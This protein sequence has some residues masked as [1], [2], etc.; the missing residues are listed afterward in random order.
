MIRKESASGKMGWFQPREQADYISK[1][2]NPREIRENQ[3]TSKRNFQ[4]PVAYFRGRI[5]HLLQ[6]DATNRAL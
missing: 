3:E 2:R 6:K 5:N 4:G 1:L